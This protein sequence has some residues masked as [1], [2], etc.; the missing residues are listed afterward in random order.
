MEEVDVAVN[1]SVAV[2]REGSSVRVPVGLAVKVSVAVEVWK[3]V[4]VSVAVPV[5]VGV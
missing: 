2:V 3:G 5:A 4:K 1:G